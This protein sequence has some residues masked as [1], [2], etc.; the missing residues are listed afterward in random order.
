MGQ[1]PEDAE[2]LF[3]TRRILVRRR[4]GG[5]P[6]AYVLDDP[7]GNRLGG[8]HRTDIQRRKR[9][10]RMI[11]N[12]FE[13]T[14]SRPGVRLDVTDRAGAAIFSVVLSPE[15]DRERA[16]VRSAGDAD[17]G[18][19]VKAKGLRKIRFDLRSGG[20][21][22]GTVEAEGW[23]G[24]EYR[25]DRSGAPVGRITMV[26]EKPVFRISQTTDD[27]LLE[28]DFAL[29]EPLRTLVLACAVALDVSVSSD[30]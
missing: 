20:V 11:T 25:I 10:L 8:V 28:L 4:A 2:R 21:L 18:E 30:E 15:D 5:G 19:I 23:S 29:D 9:P 16:V 6:D 7:D 17:L 27:F 12:F 3:E 24:W 1:H 14:D 13:W 26:K 22:L